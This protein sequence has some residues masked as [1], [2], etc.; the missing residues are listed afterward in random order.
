M[1]QILAKVFE[2]GGSGDREIKNRQLVVE[3]I[4]QTKILPL[5]TL[6]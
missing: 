4:K 1:R 3:D 2:I 5:M 6:I